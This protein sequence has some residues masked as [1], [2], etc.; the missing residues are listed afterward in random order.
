[1]NRFPKAMFSSR[2]IIYHGQETA[3]NGAQF[4]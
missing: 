2:E 3:D 1:M 4:H